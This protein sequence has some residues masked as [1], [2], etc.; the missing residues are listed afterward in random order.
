MYTVKR[1]GVRSAIKVG[2]ILAAMLV[3]VP[4]VIFLVLNG[5]F[6]FWDVIIP[7]ELMIQGLSSMAFWAAIWGGITTGM[8]AII[9]NVSAH[10][11][12]GLEVEL[13]SPPPPRKRHETIDIE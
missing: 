11:F 4:V 5:L 3:V 8:V 6:K 2:A 12:G 13:K 1:I 10:F 9:Y 7:P